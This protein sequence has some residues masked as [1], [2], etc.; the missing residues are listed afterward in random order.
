M[1]GAAFLLQQQQIQAVWGHTEVLL[2]LGHNE[3]S[4]HVEGVAVWM[5]RHNLTVL[6]VD[7]QEPG[8]IK[9][10]NRCLWPLCAAQADLLTTEKE[11]QQH[12][13]H[14]R[15]RKAGNSCSVTFHYKG[16]RV[17]GTG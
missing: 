2:S 16:T 5:Y 1:S 11:T 14:E 3:V 9:A 12:R 15:Q 7:L 6:L 4:Q 10:H 8:V 13:S 17:L